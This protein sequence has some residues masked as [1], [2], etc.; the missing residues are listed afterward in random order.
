MSSDISLLKSIELLAKFTTQDNAGDT[1]EKAVDI[2][3]YLGSEKNRQLGEYQISKIR[4]V[5]RNAEIGWKLFKTPP[6]VSIE[7]S[8]EECFQIFALISTLHGFCYGVERLD[9]ASF[10]TGPDSIPVRFY[11]NSVYHYIAALFLLDKGNDPL[12]GTVYKTLVKMDLA[13]LLAPIE[14]VLNKQMGDGISFGETVRKIRNKFL[15]H[16]TFLATDISSVVKETQLRERAQQLRLTNYIWDLFN[17]VFIL[18]LKLI[19]LVNL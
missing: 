17:R 10:E 2:S 9:Y 12:G 19:A 7:L 14:K 8:D 5:A 13:D 16:G 1:Y 18:K 6:T 4:S 3:T 11:I 15:V